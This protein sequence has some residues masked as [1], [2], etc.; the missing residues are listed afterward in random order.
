M[1]T[2][3]TPQEL[4][5]KDAWVAE[6]FG[7]EIVQSEFHPTTDAACSR[8]LEE[9]L[10][11]RHILTIEASPSGYMVSKLQEMSDCFWKDYCTVAPNLELALVLF[12]EKLYSK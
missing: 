4:L 3:F 7:L 1:K 6:K 9:K 12:A 11:E 5:A 8:I 10:M 2:S